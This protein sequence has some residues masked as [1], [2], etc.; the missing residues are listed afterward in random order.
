MTIRILLVWEFRSIFIL[1]GAWKVVQNGDGCGVIWYKFL[2][3]ALKENVRRCSGTQDLRII[4]QNLAYLR[5]RLP[6][7]LRV[8]LKRHRGGSDQRPGLLAGTLIYKEKN[9]QKG[10]VFFGCCLI[11]W[12]QEEF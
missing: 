9:E 3:G 12:F 1:I 6:V 5:R 11:G 7:I 10:D 4:C 8:H 2:T